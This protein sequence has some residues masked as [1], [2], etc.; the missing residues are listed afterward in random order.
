VEQPVLVV[1]WYLEMTDAAELRPAG[2]P[3]VDARFHRAEPDPASSRRFYEQVGRDWSWTDRRCWNAGQ[4]EAWVSAPGYEM[5]LAEVA[6]AAVGY[7]ELDG[8]PQGDVQVAYLGI[9]PGFTGKGLGGALLTAG[10]D[11][12]WRRGAER[13]WLHTCSLDAPHARANYLARGFRPYDF[14]VRRSHRTPAG[15]SEPV[16]E[17]EVVVTPRRAVPPPAAGHRGP[18]TAPRGPARRGRP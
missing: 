3:L 15:A 10:V 9:L 11:R 1:A 8:G 5:W 2:P 13:V 6:G 4:W 7:L 12:A 14:V 18:G 16:A 17:H